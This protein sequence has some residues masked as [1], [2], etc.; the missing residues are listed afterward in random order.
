[1]KN[2]LILSLIWVLM[3]NCSVSAETLKILNWSDYIDED[4]LAEFAASRN[5]E[6][7]YQ[8]YEDLSEF[9]FKFFIETNEYDIVFPPIDGFH[10]M[11]ERGSLSKIK[12]SLLS[13]YKNLDSERLKQLESYD[14][15]NSYSL[16][17]LWGTTGIGINVDKVT[18]ILGTDNFPRSWAL[19][20]T[21]EYAEKLQECG[22]SWL[23]NEIEMLQA[24]LNFQGKNPKS[25]SRADF[26]LAEKHLST[27][28][29][30]VKTFTS[31]EYIEPFRDGD[32][33]A[34]IGYSGDV[35]QAIWEAEELENGQNLEYF[36][37]NEGSSVWIDIVT[38]TSTAN[39]KLAYDFLNALMDPEIIAGITNYVWYANSV[40][41][42]NPFIDEEITA[43]ESIYPNTNVMKSL[44]GAPVYK[45]SILRSMQRRWVKVKCSA[46]Q[47]CL[48]PIDAIPGK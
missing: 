45:E 46:G 28:A 42:S 14:P 9:D 21:P 22:V 25:E 10:K 23:D 35:F 19:L 41:K 39:Q 17:Y 48:V 1:M 36:I 11:V 8:T 2:S 7:D 15:G 33:C 12:K 20:F 5:I 18:E 38:M 29:K 30:T 37:P 47:E 31:E 13:N 32:L 34:V 40:P 16:P 6:I 3:L 43:D 4:F 44:Y 27:V 26:R 24:S